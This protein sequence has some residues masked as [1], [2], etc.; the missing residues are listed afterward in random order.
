Y[1]QRITPSTIDIDGEPVDV[2]RNPVGC[3]DH[4]F[5]KSSIR[6]V[7]KLILAF[8]EIVIKIKSN[9]RFQAFDDG[10]CQPTTQCI[11]IFFHAC[12]ISI[13][14]LE[15]SSNEESCPFTPTRDT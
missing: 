3:S 10:G 13:L 12:V 15:A 1:G 7:P 2:H 8:P 5:K 11:F 14:I 6:L 9:I 4:R